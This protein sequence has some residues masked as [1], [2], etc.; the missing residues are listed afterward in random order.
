VQKAQLA[1]L[2]YLQAFVNKRPGVYYALLHAD[3]DSMGKV[4]DNQTKDKHHK[5]SQRLAAFAG[6]VRQIVEQD[7]RGALVYAGGDDVLAFLPVDTVLAC[8]EQLHKTFAE[9]VGEGTFASEDGTL[10]TLS[11]GIAVCHH[12]EPLS[13]AL[14][15]VRRAEHSA[16]HVQNAAGAIV[17]NGLAI[18]VEKRSGEPQ[19]IAGH[20]GDGFYERLRQLIT[21]MHNSELSAGAPYELRDLT[22]RLDEPKELTSESQTRHRAVAE[23]AVR[24]IERKRGQRG[25]QKLHEAEINQVREWLGLPRKEKGKPLISDLGNRYDVQQ[26]TVRQLA[27]ELIVAREFA[28][29]A[30]TDAAQKGAQP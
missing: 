21:L 5:L 27:N 24:I 11:V 17:K 25:N 3:G 7:H 12:L 20:W 2:A 26:I 15:L 14:A 29:Y 23:E 18:A 10:P 22:E 8:A 16:K 4:I 19:M 13:E 9:H 1:L 28:R 6:G 30:P